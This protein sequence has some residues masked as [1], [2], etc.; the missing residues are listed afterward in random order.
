[1]AESKSAALPLGYAPSGNECIG[2]QPAQ[3]KADQL[4]ANAPPHVHQFG[5]RNRA[6]AW[7]AAPGSSNRP[8]HVAP[9]PLIRARRQPG[10]PAKTLITSPMTGCNAMAG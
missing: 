6:A 4:P 9:E 8:K 7:A 2:R 5:R 10:T 3:V 1:M